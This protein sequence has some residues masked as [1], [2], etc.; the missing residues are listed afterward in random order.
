ME[1]IVLKSTGSWYIVQCG[2]ERL[3]CRVRGKFR[4][5]DE[6]KATN[7]VAVGDRVEVEKTDEEGIGTIT[8]LCDRKNYIIRKSSK[9]S[10]QVHILASNIDQGIL[11]GSLKKPRTSTGFI[12]RFLVTCEAYEIPAVIIFNKTDLLNDKLQSEL[13][14]ICGIYQNL[15]YRFEQISVHQKQNLHA[16]DEILKKK[17]SLLCGHSGVGKSSLINTLFPE[18]KIKTLDISNWSGKGKHSTTFAQMHEL[19]V[20]TWIIDTPGIREFGIIKLDEL[21]LGHYFPEIR[22]RMSGCKFHNCLHQ[23]EPRCAVKNAVEKGEIVDFRYES[24]LR[25]LENIK[26]E[27]RK[28]FQ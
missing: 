2:K 1:G 4:L 17:I 20:N 5:N 13:D 15:G 25:I 19:E 8:Q 9:L 3:E 23:N 6:L 18:L 7:P 10:K 27:E 22:Q 11:M 26:E 28:R 12:D 24:Y 21:D 14:C 16:V